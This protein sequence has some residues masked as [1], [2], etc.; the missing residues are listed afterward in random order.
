MLA[1][2][3]QRLLTEVDARALAKFAWNFGARGLAGFWRFR[4]R[5]ARGENFPAV[6]FVSLTTRC[7]L[8]CQGCWVSVDGPV[9]SVAPADLHR[10]IAAG[11]RQGC[12]FYGLL[13][14]EPLLY[15]P[16]WDVLA[17]HRDCYFQL[18]TNGTLLTADDARRMRRLGNVTPLVSIEGLAEV[19]DERRGGR[20]VYRKALEALEHCRRERLLLGVA[21]SLC[22][23]NLDELATDSFVRDCVRRGVHYLWYYI[24]RPA[25]ALPAPEL[26]LSGEQILRL[27]QFLVEARTWASLMIVDAYWDHLGRGLCPAATGVSYHVN[28][29]LDVEPC[30]PIQ[31]AVENLAGAPP[32]ETINRSALL[33]DFRALAA[34]T[35]RG[36][37]LLERPDLLRHFLLDRG[38]RDTSG[39]GTGYDELAAACPHPSHGSVEAIP[40]RHWLYR[41]AKKHWFFGF[42]AYG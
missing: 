1:R 14:G 41:F 26:A 28:P 33:R 20:D 12:Y 6:L 24:Y 37:I 2:L 5:L 19:S 23:S 32:V 10:L 8:R 35:S 22:R 34:G 31:F 39:R 16:L 25:G 3:A 4:R 13:G 27:R 11:K 40:E 7:N 9:Q 29:W 17:R 15:D 21:T 42:G 18:F 38:A 30:P 36:C